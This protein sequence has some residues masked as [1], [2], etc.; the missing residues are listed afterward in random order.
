MDYRQTYTL[1]D[2]GSE[3]VMPLTRISGRLGVQSTGAG[4]VVQ[5]QIM[6]N[7]IEGAISDHARRGQGLANVFKRVG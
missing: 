5:P 6:I 2:A 4:V 7:Q 3:A 1:P